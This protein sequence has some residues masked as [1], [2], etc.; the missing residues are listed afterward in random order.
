M[1]IKAIHFELV[2]D[3]STPAFIAALSRF[4]SRRGKP[5]D[6]YCDGGT[7]F[8]GTKNE[9]EEIRSFLTSSAHQTKIVQHAAQLGIKFHV[10]PPASPHH[11]GLWEAGVKSMKKHLRR[12]MGSRHMT[13]EE[14]STLLCQVEA[15]LNSRPITAMSSDP[16]DLT[17]LTPGHFLIGR[18]L[19]S[20]PQVDITHIPENRL[21]RW[22]DV[23]QRSQHLWKRFESEYL[24]LL[25]SRPKKLLEPL[26]DLAPGLLVLIRESDSPIG[27]Q[28]WR[29]GRLV[30]I[31]PG[32]DD[33]TRICDVKTGV[34]PQNPHG[35]ILRRPIVKLSPL[36]IYN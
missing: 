6:I 13:V 2:T 1:V 24:T 35:N 31:H 10:N 29:L 17:A 26:T 20:L 32:T 33:L 3:L 34:T 4:T 9:F 23:Q 7:N 11:G 28:H 25:H 12:V 15:M 8:I 21:S 22:Q 14:F 18:P 19:Q 30:K 27:P 16:N 36:P 5:D